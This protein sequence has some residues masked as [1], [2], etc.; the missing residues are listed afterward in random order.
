VR[1]N[2]HIILRDNTL[3]GEEPC[4]EAPEVVHKARGVMWR[5]IYFHFTS[6]KCVAQPALTAHEKALKRGYK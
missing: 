2:P 5:G 1:D 4:N 6:R 3:V